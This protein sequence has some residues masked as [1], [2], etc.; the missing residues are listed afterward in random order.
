MITEQRKEIPNLPA[1][2]SGS[3]LQ[4]SVGSMT[5]TPPRLVVDHVE[6]DALLDERLCQLL[7]ND[8]AYRAS[9]STREQCGHACRVL[10]DELDP[11]TPY[12]RI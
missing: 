8:A 1:E 3:R 5:A 6:F 12:A 4:V 2:F 11:E 9:Q 7:D 10:R